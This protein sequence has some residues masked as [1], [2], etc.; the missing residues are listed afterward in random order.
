M[1]TEE[2]KAWTASF[3]VGDLVALVE[4]PLGAA[5]KAGT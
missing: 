3:K 5:G 2:V 1:T 4:N